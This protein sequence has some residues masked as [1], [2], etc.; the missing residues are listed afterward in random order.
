MYS[1]EYWSGVLFSMLNMY[2]QIYNLFAC[3]QDH[4]AVHQRRHLL[5]LWISPQDNRPLPEEYASL[6]NSTQPGQRGGFS[7]DRNM[8]VPLEAE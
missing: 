6:W 2:I 7:A 1:L 8:T 4:E 5:R 3:L